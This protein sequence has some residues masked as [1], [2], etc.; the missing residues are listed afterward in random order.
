MAI[1]RKRIPKYGTVQ[2]NGH[3]YYKTSVL[4]ADGK[5]VLLYGK[6]RA[7]LYEKEMEALEQIDIHIAPLREFSFFDKKNV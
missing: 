2:I 5:K 3:T 1:S 4:D 7:E 6:T